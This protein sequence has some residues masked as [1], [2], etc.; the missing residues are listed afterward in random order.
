MCELPAVLDVI[1]RNAR[2]KHI[3]CECGC[4]IERGE[5][6]DAIAG[7]WD[8]A[9]LHHKQCLECARAMIVAAGYCSQWELN[10]GEG[11]WYSGVWE[12]WGERDLVPPEIAKMRGWKAKR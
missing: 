9:W 3:C 7:C 1:T 8:G 6:Y 11:P 10:S 5:L 2:R 4:T 12:W